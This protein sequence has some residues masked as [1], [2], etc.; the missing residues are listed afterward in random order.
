MPNNATKAA[1][2]A[3][4]VSVFGLEPE[5]SAFL[6]DVLTGT[7]VFLLVSDQAGENVGRIETTHSTP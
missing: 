1:N 6:V 4:L 7:F 5:A 2:K 3:W